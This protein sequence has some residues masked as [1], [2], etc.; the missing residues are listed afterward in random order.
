VICGTFLVCEVV[1]FDEPVRFNSLATE[2]RNTAHSPV[3]AAVQENQTLPT[4]QAQARI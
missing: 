1:V 2:Y 4:I 3:V